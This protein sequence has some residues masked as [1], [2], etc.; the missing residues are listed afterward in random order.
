[1]KTTL[2]IIGIF[3]LIITG[4]IGYLYKKSQSMEINQGGVSVS[5]VYHG[6]TT[7]E[8]LVWTDQ[9]IKEGSGSLGSVVI[10]LA[11]NL[12]F[13]L[14]NATTTN[15]NART[16]NKATSTILLTS[17]PASLIAGTYVYDIAYFDGL[18]L[19]VKSGSLGTSTITYR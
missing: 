6:T 8:G 13:D 2:I 12:S 10:S 11:G 19:D 16:G 18:Y 3:M 7:P 14:L 5:N 1:M 17:I 9:I 4:I 15:I